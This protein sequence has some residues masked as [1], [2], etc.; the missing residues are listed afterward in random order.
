[1]RSEIVDVCILGAGMAGLTLARQLQRRNPG[2]SIALLEHRQF[3]VA[4]AVHK[5]GES[6]VEI[7][8]QYLA[9]DLDLK[10]HLQ[11]QQLPKFGLRLFVRGEQPVTD[12]IAGYDE[13]GVSRV[14]P[15]PTYQ[16]D[17]GRLEN[18]LA[19]VVRK[20]GAQLLSGAT[21]RKVDLQ[22]GAHQVVVRTA[23]SEQRLSARYLVDASGRRAWLRNQLNL[24]KRVRHANHAVWYRTGASF[25]LENWS[26][27][28]AW[29][30]RC[31]GTPRRLSTNHFT[32][33][34]Y[35]LWL[36]PLA[37][38]CTSIGLVFDPAW[39]DLMEVNSHDKLLHWLHS[40]HPLVAEN[41]AGHA[42]LDIHVL[43]DYAVSSQQMFSADGWMLSGDAGVFADPFYSPGADFI[44]FANG[45]ISELICG[46]GT[47]DHWRKFQQYFL[48]FYSNTLS[49]YRGQYGGFGDRNM[50]LMK[51]VW[52]YSYYWGPLAKLYF[53][54]RYTDLD[55]MDQAQ[56]VL[57]EAAALNS[58]MQRNFRKLAKTGMR[59]GGEGRFF[60]HHEIPLF[61][62][63][64]E[65]LLQGDS[66]CF[67]AELQA[68]VGSLRCL[69]ATLEE[70]MQRV[71]S[72]ATMPGLDELRQAPAF[73]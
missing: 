41:L 32:G 38:G 70:T 68:S 8:A 24:G 13:I 72:G 20:A 59:I 63:I 46:A 49:L 71:H 4:E 57:L 64:K 42:A 47:V 10:Q 12:D 21:I 25:D 50:M 69:S 56:P 33:P 60:D 45:F 26:D 30:S 54:G 1:M 11:E 7:A 67:G 15:I 66:D 17:R 35:W 53:S 18:H 52:D 44:A 14:L 34:G 9:E 48:T 31:H 39:V 73:A 3:P 65:E 62:R 16:I 5:V 40:E 37:S 43:K 61:H 27:N 22:P 28:A 19:A 51:T 6:T 55:F 36:I 2:L 29:Q 23:E 58:G